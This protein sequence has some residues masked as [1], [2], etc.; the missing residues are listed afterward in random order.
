MRLNFTATCLAVPLLLVPL[1][2]ACGER[3]GSA[4]AAGTIDGETS[5]GT[6]DDASDP[7][8]DA[9]PDDASRDGGPFVCVITRCGNRLTQCGDCI[10]NDGDGHIDAQD[11]ECLGPCD[12]TEGPALEPGVG[13][14]GSATCG[15]DCFFDFGVGSGNDDCFWDHRCDPLYPR[16]PIGQCLGMPGQMGAPSQAQCNAWQADQRT[17]CDMVCAPMTPN[18]CD[19]FGCCTFANASADGTQPRNIYIGAHDGQNGTCRF[20]N[21]TDPVACPSCTQVASCTNACGMC[22]VCIDRPVPPPECTPAQQCPDGDQ[23]CGL[24]GQPSCPAGTY[25]ITGC[26]EAG[27]P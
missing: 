3:D 2:S 17:T 6:S 15:V 12:N 24:P 20:D 16:Q 5:D 27:I 4:D 22:E 11:R 1:L 7:T 10:D 14:V 23:P 9:T 26:C 25:C 19:C 8:T 21:I 18:G 13:G